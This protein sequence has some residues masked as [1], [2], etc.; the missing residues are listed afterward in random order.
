MYPKM[1]ASKY[2]YL[3][4]LSAATKDLIQ[5]RSEAVVTTYRQSGGY[6]DI[7]EFWEGYKMHHWLSWADWGSQVVLHGIVLLDDPEF[8][9]LVR[10]VHAAIVWFMYPNDSTAVGYWDEFGVAYGA[11]Y[12][13]AVY[14]H[15]KPLSRRHLTYNLHV[16]LCQI[17]QQVQL[18]GHP[19]GDKELWVERMIKSAKFFVQGRGTR[20]PEAV[21]MHAYL[22]I[23]AMREFKLKYGSKEL[24]KMCAYFGF[25]VDEGRTDA[26]GTR[27]GD[28]PDDIEYKECLGWRGQGMSHRGTG[29]GAVAA[30]VNS[31]GFRQ[32]GY[33]HDDLDNL[34]L[35]FF[36]HGTLQRRAPEAP[37]MQ[38]Q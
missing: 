21:I 22:V 3:G 9:R 11:I 38:Q 1:N 25:R 7:V 27:R 8:D 17:A 13:W 6:L 31:R 32:G 14:A 12:D 23:M 36:H 35:G 28:D 20:E 26:T 5:A 34:V 33:S 30:A 18:R 16:F 2:H 15:R 29:M 4:G 10:R 19:A 37:G 24:A